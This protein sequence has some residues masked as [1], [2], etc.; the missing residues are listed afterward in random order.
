[1]KE[2]MAEV[3]INFTINREIPASFQRILER[4]LADCL[5]KTL[6]EELGG[7]DYEEVHALFVEFFDVAEVEDYED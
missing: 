3:Q 4:S 2:V 6:Y 5:D 1:M 7:A